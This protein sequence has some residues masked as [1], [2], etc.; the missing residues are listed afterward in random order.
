MVRQD[1]ADDHPVPLAL[2][3]THWRMQCVSW[4]TTGAA[5]G[6]RHADYGSHMILGGLTRVIVAGNPL[7]AWV[8]TVRLAMALRGPQ[9][10]APAPGASVC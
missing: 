2:H 5:L 7:G 3:L 1:W 4:T 10:D 8:L 9:H 6:L